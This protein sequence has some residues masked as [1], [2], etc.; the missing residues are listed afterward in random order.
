MSGSPPWQRL[1]TR[2]RKERA[3]PTCADVVNDGARHDLLTVPSPLESHQFSEA[4]QV[5]QR[6]VQT[7]PGEFGSRRV[8]RE[9][10]VVLGAEA[11]EDALLEQVAQRLPL[12]RR[13]TAPS[14]SA[15]TV[16][17]ANFS[18]CGIAFVTV[19]K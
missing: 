12:T 14:V 17:Y 7:A 18:P 6:K 3:I 13:R 5:A 16:L 15:F 1:V 10:R 9:V 19:L 11:T 4:S 8:H 2:T